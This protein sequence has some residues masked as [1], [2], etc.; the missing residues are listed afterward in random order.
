[1]S[2]TFFFRLVRA[3]SLFKRRRHQ[4]WT[5]ACT[6]TILAIISRFLLM[7]G[8]IRE[9]VLHCFAK[10]K[11]F[12]Y[13]SDGYSTTKVGARRLAREFSPGPA[14]DEEEFFEEESQWDDAQSAWNVLFVSGQKKVYICQ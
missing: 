6:L 12:A 4:K 11:T 10:K 7:K 14:N 3:T 13:S 9:K 1:M 8:E 2:Q 5:P